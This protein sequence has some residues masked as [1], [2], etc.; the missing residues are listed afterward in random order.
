M[1]YNKAIKYINHYNKINEDFSKIAG[2][3]NS[4][5]NK[6]FANI[7]RIDG[8]GAFRSD[9]YYNTEQ[10]NLYYRCKC[11]V[12]NYKKENDNKYTF[13][14]KNITILNGGRIETDNK[15]RGVFNSKNKVVFYAKG[16]LPSEMDKNDYK[17]YKSSFNDNNSPIKNNIIILRNKS[18]NMCEVYIKEN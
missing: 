7:I 13:Y 3:Y 18:R 17:A 16:T 1:S 5:N 10:K 2:T 8:S 9:V 6:K 12:E 4:K 11:L 14:L 15:S